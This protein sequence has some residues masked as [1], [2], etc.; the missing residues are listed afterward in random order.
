MLRFIT[1]YSNIVAAIG[2]WFNSRAKKLP[3]FFQCLTIVDIDTVPHKILWEEIAMEFK[4]K[5]YTAEML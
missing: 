1:H 5:K 2:G 4:Y 3:E